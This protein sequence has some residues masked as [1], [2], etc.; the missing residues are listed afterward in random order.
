[1]AIC[2]LINNVEARSN[3]V[4]ARF[5]QLRNAHLVLCH[6]LDALPIRRSRRSMIA[7]SASR[8]R[9][10]SGRHKS[11]LANLVG[12]GATLYVRGVARGCATLDLKPFA[13]LELAIAA[14][15][16]AVGYCFTESRMLPSVLTGEKMVGESLDAPGVERR[17]NAVT[18]ELLTVRHLDGVERV[19]IFSLR[20][21]RGCV[22]YDL[23]PEDEAGADVPLV[24]QLANRE[25]RHRNVGALIAVNRLVGMEPTQL[26]PFNLTIDDRPASFDHFNA[27]PLSALLRHI[28]YLCPGAHT[29]FAWT[30]SHTRPC[31]GYLKTMR[32]FST[33]FVWHG[34][35][36]H[37]NHRVISNPAA[38]LMEGRRWVRRIEQRFGIRFQPIMIFPFEVSAP[39]QFPLLAQAG[40]LASVEAPQAEFLASDGRLTNPCADPHL[41]SPCADPHL[42]RYFGDS[43]PAH[44]D[45]TSDLT[46]LYRY[47]ASSLTRERMLAMA[48]LGLPI[49]AAAHPKNVGLKRFS[50]FR[51]RGGDFSHFDEILKFASSKGLRSLSLE[52]IAI[53]VRNQQRANDPLTHVM[54]AADGP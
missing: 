2:F 47:A 52:H 7:I 28:D 1:M 37:V 43:L 34:L 15:H 9:E 19:A 8:L 22:I 16:R 24:E 26:P 32:D 20:Y 40:F 46:I 4:A 12:E 13:S 41:P 45:V 30:P 17:F 51:D 11:H 10:L 50:R 21:G 6:D 54:Q 33:G 29:D 36:R 39:K 27:A 44:V 5:A 31:R 25:V 42:P 38:E 3:H 53:E 49:I 35:S 48:A 18:E 23:A 14:E